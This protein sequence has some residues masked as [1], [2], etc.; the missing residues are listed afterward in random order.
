MP[1]APHHTALVTGA[2]DGLGLEVARRL[3]ASGTTVLVHGRNEEKLGRVVSELGDKAEAYLADLSS[4]AEARTLA[5]KVA[6]EHTDLDIL[7]NNAGVAT[8][9]RQTSADGYELDFAVNY[10][11]HFL[12]T[13]ELLP[14]LRETPDSRIVNVSSIGQAPVDFDDVMLEHD[15]SWSAGRAYSQSKLAQILFTIELA[16]RLPSGESPT[17]TALHPSTYM[18]TNMVRGMGTTPISTVAE[19]AE[20][21]LRLAVGDDV[22][23]V[24]GRFYDVR[25]EADADPQADDA[26]ARS[27]LWA[28]SAELTG[29]DFD[30]T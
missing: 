15:G 14:L 27:R 28:L 10:L 26:E 8:M 11:S 30:R 6:A 17:V 2:T 3:A 29:L 12:I 7:I 1:T 18:D 23:G 24:T 21:T 25:D 19:G 16:E 22:N 9:E 4:L 20:A 13:L 5:E